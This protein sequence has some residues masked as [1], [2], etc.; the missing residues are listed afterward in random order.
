MIISREAREALE[1]QFLAPYA[2]FSRA[3]Q[4]RQH[5][6][7][8]DPYRTAFQRDRDRILHTAAF[9]RLE[10]K[11]QVFVNYE[12]DY[13]RTRLTH[14]LEVAQI[15]RSIARA[16][17][18]N[19]DLVE[20]I[21]L[22]HDLGHSPF[23]HAGETVLN[24]LMRDHGGFNHNHQSYRIVTVLETRYKGWQGLNLTYEMLEG[25]AKHETEYDL[26]AV[27]GYDPNLRGSL[28]AQIANMADEL[29]YNAH[30]LDDGLRS[31]LIVPEQ[32]AELELWQRVTADVGWQ[33]GKLDDITRH[34]IIR[35]LIHI[36]NVDAIQ[37]TAATLQASGVQTRQDIQRLPYN[38]VGHSQDFQRMN[39]QLKD[40]LYQNLYR[41]YRVVRMSAKARRFL[42]DLFNA[43]VADPHQMP[44]SAQARIAQDGVHRAVTD[45][46]AGM[47]DRY[48]LQEW[49][50][51]FDPF[52]RT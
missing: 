30:D 40:F 50:R 24:E 13:Y 8:P 1:E 14:T 6:E 2:T 33:G 9:R 45:Y 27:T 42:T 5:A 49:Q 21:C 4:G 46:L 39:R 31:G 35:R 48:A 3:S 7:P 47:T 11:T 17:G 19:E 38:V 43:F 36:E 12:G 22:A 10:Y 28:E 32:L 25:I 41:H 20:G 29:A 37:A 15:G 16:L 18:A 26:S 23:G 44:P 51:L 34:Q 52:T